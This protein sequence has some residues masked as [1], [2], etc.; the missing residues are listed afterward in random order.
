MNSSV[1][2]TSNTVINEVVY[3]RHISGDFVSSHKH[4]LWEVLLYCDGKGRVGFGNEEYEYN[5]NT[6]VLVS[7]EMLHS[8]NS[9]SQTYS[10][11]KL[12]LII[13]S[14]YNLL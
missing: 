7:P 6:V 1:I 11:S 8:E 2:E 12:S 9:F 5:N 3:Y 13:P 4:S 10:T 14:L